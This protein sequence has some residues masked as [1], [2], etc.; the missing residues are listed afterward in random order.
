MRSRAVG[1]GGDPGSSVSAIGVITPRRSSTHRPQLGRAPGELRQRDAAGALEL[2]DAE[3][4]EQ[5]GHR[6]E[7]VGRAGDLIVI[8]S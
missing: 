6:V 2:D 8:A 1:A 4:L 7:L 3:R 5:V